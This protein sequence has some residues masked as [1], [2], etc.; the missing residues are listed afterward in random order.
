MN[1]QNKKCLNIY[2]NNG[3]QRATISNNIKSVKATN[4]LVV[5]NATKD[6][7]SIT[8]EANDHCPYTIE[9]STVK[10]YVAVIKKGL[11]TDLEMEKNDVRYLIFENLIN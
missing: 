1:N 6:T 3:T 4:E 7:Y 10:D 9:V 8:L 5:E 11:F 2:I